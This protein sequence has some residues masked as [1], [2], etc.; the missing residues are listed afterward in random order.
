MAIVLWNTHRLASGLARNQVPP[1]QRFVYLVLSNVIW[2]SAGYIGAFVVRPSSGWL[3]WYEFF[4]VL[5]VTVSG[6]VRCRERYRGLADDRLLEACV[7]LGVPLSI[8]FLL[9]TWLAYAAARWALPWLFL[10]GRFSLL[11]SGNVVDL[12]MR[13]VFMFS[14]FLIATIAAAVYYLR[15]STHLATVARGPNGT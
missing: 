5:I 11:D 6:L 15:L 14:P 8:K 13:V 12:L 7:I 2:L 10:S 1:E 9:L 4:L 3:Y